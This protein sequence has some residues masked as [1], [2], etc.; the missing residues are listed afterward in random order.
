M[1]C[2]HHEHAQGYITSS[3]SGIGGDEPLNGNV[4]AAE[5]VYGGSG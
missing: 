1:P 4:V 5:K 2:S 3:V